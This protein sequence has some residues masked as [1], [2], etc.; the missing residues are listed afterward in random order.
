MWEI[1]AND[2]PCF[3]TAVTADYHD[4]FLC[5][6]PQT[7]R[8]GLECYLEWHCLALVPGLRY[9]FISVCYTAGRLGPANIKPYPPAQ[10][11]DKR[12]WPRAIHGGQGMRAGNNRKIYFRYV[13]NLIH[14]RGHW[15]LRFHGLGIKGRIVYP[16]PVWKWRNC[17]SGLFMEENWT[18]LRGWWLKRI[19][20]WRR[21]TR[22]KSMVRN[23]VT[24]VPKCLF[25]KAYSRDLLKLRPLSCQEKSVF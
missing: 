23:A 5:Q 22:D 3:L 15:W 13:E 21:R 1:S 6:W 2:T 19:V 25:Y 18:R 24:C 8:F 12:K 4:L 20:L 9:S 14:G 11:S 7:F 10:T 17:L 16:D